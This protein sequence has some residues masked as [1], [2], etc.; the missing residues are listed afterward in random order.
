M[1][2]DKIPTVDEKI[3]GV[4]LDESLKREHA[5]G[6]ISAAVYSGFA[7]RE[8]QPR[9][10]LAAIDTAQGIRGRGGEG[11]GQNAQRADS[12]PPRPS[13][14]EEAGVTGTPYASDTAVPLKVHAQL[15][16]RVAQLLEKP[17]TPSYPAE[18]FF[19]AKTMFY[20]EFHNRTGLVMA[21]GSCI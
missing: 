11:D 12:G 15:G 21:L 6:R 3:L 9:E 8:A 20:R 7:G 19:D 14:T 1:D 13:G 10:P 16:I 5:T 2:V 17:G 18:P 4:K